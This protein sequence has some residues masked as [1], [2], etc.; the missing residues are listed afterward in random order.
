MAITITALDRP[1]NC[2]HVTISANVDGEAKSAHVHVDDVLEIIKN[3]GLD[4][5]LVMVMCAIKYW[6]DQGDPWAQIEGRTV[7]S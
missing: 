3:S 1:A 2:G 6:R 4:Y 5:R 7:I